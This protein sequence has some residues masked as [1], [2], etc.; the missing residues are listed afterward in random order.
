MNIQRYWKARFSASK[1]KSRSRVSTSFVTFSWLATLA[2]GWYAHMLWHND[3]CYANERSLAVTSSKSALPAAMSEGCPHWDMAVQVQR[4]I[5]RDYC[6]RHFAGEPPRPELMKGYLN[7]PNRTD[8]RPGLPMDFMIYKTA[9]VISD[10]IRGGQAWERLICD[11]LVRAMETVAARRGL[12]QKERKALTFLDVGG[13]MGIHTT[14]MQ[15]AGFSVITFEPLPPNEEIIRSNLCMNDA[16]Q[17]RATLFTKGLGAVAGV[18]KEYSSP[19]YNQGNGVISC[20]G[21]IPQHDDGPVTFKGQIEIVPLDDLWR[22]GEENDGYNSSEGN[23]NNQ[24]PR[25]QL[26]QLPIGAMKMDVEGFEPEVVAGATRFL[27]NTRIPYIVMEVGRM[28]PVKRRQVLAFFYSLGY[29]VGVEGFFDQELH[30]PVDLPNVEDAYFVLK[31]S[32]WM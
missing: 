23:Q 7:G 15:A 1:H 4:Q 27:T 13:N 11:Q 3:D 17:E 29:E 26:P 9:D 8:G 20:D 24:R 16:A 32:R 14:Y 31:E 6:L 19:T 22:C 28:G 25:F 10:Y 2:L 21:S 5:Q 18:C 30:R 12:S